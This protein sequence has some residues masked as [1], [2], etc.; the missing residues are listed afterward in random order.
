MSL[1]S[2]MALSVRVQQCHCA[3]ECKSCNNMS[4]GDGRPVAL[5]AYCPAVSS[6]R[7]HYPDLPR[8]LA[9]QLELL[10]R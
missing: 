9:V 1:I 6:L 2:T 3:D 10:H 8:E 5:H 7:V 4:A